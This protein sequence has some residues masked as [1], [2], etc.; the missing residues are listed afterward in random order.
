MFV[1]VVLID[2]ESIGSLF[3]RIFSKLICFLEEILMSYLTDFAS[4]YLYSFVVCSGLLLE[5]HLLGILSV[6]AKSGENAVK[7]FVLI[8]DHK[9]LPAIVLQSKEESRVNEPLLQTIGLKDL[10]NSLFERLYRKYSEEGVTHAYDFLSKQGRMHPEI[11]AFPSEYFYEGRLESVGLPHQLEENYPFERLCFYPVKPSEKDPSDKANLHEAEKTVAICRELYEYMQT[12]GESFNPQ[13]IGIITPYRNQIALIRKCLQE[14]GIEAF[15]AIT[16]DT[17]ERFQGS[18]RD[19]IIY[20]FCVK[21][22][23]Q[24]SALPNIVEE[25][26]RIIDRKLNVALTRA[27]KQLYIIGNEELLK[28]NEIYGKL[29]EHVKRVK[30]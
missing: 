27:K 10:S 13:S 6:K 19:I 14:T 18:Q 16:V 7:R 30:N 22:A 15:S 11:S 4:K 5:T 20:S 1:L 29:I 23:G 21:T 17:V 12:K 3:V 9:Q 2:I 28:K 24:L 25:N 8:G 26:G